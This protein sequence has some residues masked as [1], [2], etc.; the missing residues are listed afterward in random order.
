LYLFLSFTT[1]SF[2]KWQMSM[3][4]S[5]VII[6]LTTAVIIQAVAYNSLSTKYKRLKQAIDSQYIELL[7]EWMPEETRIIKHKESQ[8]YESFRG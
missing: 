3:G 8:K 2:L 4:K 1:V 6:F 5:L 7:Y